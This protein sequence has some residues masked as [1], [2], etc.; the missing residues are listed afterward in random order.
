MRLEAVCIA[1]LLFMTVLATPASAGAQENPPCPDRLLAD[2]IHEAVAALDEA[3]AAAVALMEEVVWMAVGELNAAIILVNGLVADVIGTIN[4]VIG[5]VNRLLVD[6]FACIGRGLS[7]DPAGAVS[8]IMGLLESLGPVGQLMMFVV[9]YALCLLDPSSVCAG[10]NEVVNW[11]MGA[12]ALV[13]ELAGVVLAMLDPLFV[14]LDDAVALL[15]ALVNVLV[16]TVEDLALYVQ[17]QACAAD[18]VCPGP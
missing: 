15:L 13:E 4:D 8:L 11:I 16:G 17:Q 1:L 5:E 18:V 14:W 3:I 10:V 6:T 12:V 7:C 2:C 9:G